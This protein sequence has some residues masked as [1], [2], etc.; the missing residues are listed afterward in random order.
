MNREPCSIGVVAIGRNEGARLVQCLRSILAEGVPV[1]YVDSGSGDDSVASAKALGVNVLELDRSRPF[2]AARARN[3]GTDF[4]LDR[5]PSVEF[6]QFVDGD[7]TLARGWLLQ[8]A[9]WLRADPRQ[10]AVIGHLQEKEPRRSVYNLLCAIEWRSAPGPVSDF[11]AFGGISMFRSA[12]FREIG[13]FD[14]DVIA[15]EDSELAVRMALAGYR[16]TKL[17]A[18]MAEHDARMTRL[19]Q[20][21]KRSVRSGHAIAQRADLHGATVARD[22]VRA[23]NSVLWWALGLPLASLSLA[24]LVGAC[25]LLAPPVGYLA[26]G[27]RIRRHRLRVGDSPQEATV[28]AFFTTLAKFAQLAGLAR[29][30]WN[31]ARSRFEIIEYK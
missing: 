30:F 31:R 9:S 15:G 28:Y 27:F 8:A 16:V 23:R 29:Y 22:G 10:G 14:T 4:L 25:A 12:V 13:G 26:L 11:G 21:W 6:V 17:P 18:E 5:W 19:S 20:W 3:E 2:S 7:C 24:G 1:V